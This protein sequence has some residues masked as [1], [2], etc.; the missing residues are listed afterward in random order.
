VRVGLYPPTSL[1]SVPVDAGAGRLRVNWYTQ[2]V[3]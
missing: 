1:V 3:R 2:L